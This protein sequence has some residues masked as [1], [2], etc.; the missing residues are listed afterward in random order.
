VTL[1]SA[2]S[3]TGIACRPATTLVITIAQLC[4]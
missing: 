2:G 4:S 1:G 3:F